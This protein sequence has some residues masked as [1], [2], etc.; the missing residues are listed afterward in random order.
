MA[1]QKLLFTLS[2][3]IALLIAEFSCG[4]VESYENGLKIVNTT[5]FRI[6]P[7]CKMEIHQ[8]NDTQII[9]P[10]T[11]KR[12]TISEPP[13]FHQINKSLIIRECTLNGWKTNFDSNTCNFLYKNLFC[14]DDFHEFSTKY[15]LLCLKISKFK[16]IWNDKLCY[17]SDK[18]IFDL[19]SNE[20]SILFKYFIDKLKTNEFWLPVK[21]YNYSE[22]FNKFFPILWRLPGE[23]WGHLF[24]KHYYDHLSYNECLVLNFNHTNIISVSMTNCTT[25]KMKYN[26]CI[27]DKIITK[28]SWCPEST[29]YIRLDKPNICFGIGSY[30]VDIKH[31][32][33]SYDFFLKNKPIVNYL[34]RK[35]KLRDSKI[36][37][38][39]FIINDKNGENNSQ[40]LLITQDGTIKIE[41]DMNLKQFNYFNLNIIN[42]KQI[43]K[44]SMKLEFYEINKKLILTVYNR[45]YIFRL[46]S[47]ENDEDSSPDSDEIGISCF[48]NSDHDLIKRVE[49][50]DLIW[51]NE[52]KTESLFELKLY[53]KGPGVYWCEAHTIYDFQLIESTKVIATKKIKGNN[54][55]FFM[56]MP[57]NIIECNEILFNMKENSKKIEKTIKSAR[58]FK[59]FIKNLFKPYDIESVKIM[60]IEEILPNGIIKFICHA[61]VSD[62]F[63][64]HDDSSEE[65]SEE[66]LTYHPNMDHRTY[67][68]IRMRDYLIEILNN[69][70]NN[71]QSFQVN[72]T[73]YCLGDISGNQWKTVERGKM[74][75][76][77]EL[78]ILKNGLLKIRNCIGDFIYGATWQNLTQ[79]NDVCIKQKL[80][81]LITK[82]LYEIE[83]FDPAKDLPS[84]VL[85]SV[86]Q[87]LKNIQ[88]Q[89]NITIIAAD[90][91]YL[92]QIFQKLKNEII[93][94]SR[95][96]ESS[97]NETNHQIDLKSS[98][99]KATR[100]QFTQEFI[101]HVV[102]FNEI[103]DYLMD[104]NKTTMI[105]SVKLNSTNTILDSF[106]SII[107]S[108]STIQNNYLNETFENSINNFTDIL[109][110]DQTNKSYSDL[111]V[112]LQIYSNVMIFTIDPIIANITGIVIYSDLNTFNQNITF[113]N[114][115]YD[116]LYKNQSKEELLENERLEVASFFPESLWNRIGEIDYLA[117][118]TRVIE[119][120]RP[121]IVIKI[122]RNDALFIEN[123]EITNFKVNSK[124][125]SISIPG[126]SNK[127][128]D[129]LPIFM[130]DYQYE[131]INNE[132]G[133]NTKH[134]HY[135]NYGNWE[136]DGI[137]FVRKTHHNIANET[138]IME[139]G[140]LHLTPFAFL[141]GGTYNLSVSTDDVTITPIHEEALDIITLL[142]CS[143]S[144]IGV[145]GIFMTALVFKSWREKASTKI[146]L[147]LSIAI[148]LQMILFCFINTEVLAS[149]LIEMRIF[150]SCIILGALMH[151][152]ILVQFSWMFIIAYLQYKRYVQVL[153]N[154]RPNRFLL[155]SFLFG[156][157]VPT[158]P[159]L[160]IILIDRDAYIPVDKSKICYPTGAALYYGTLLPIAIVVSAN[161]IIFFIIFINLLRGNGVNLRH[162]EKKIAMSQLRLLILL[163]FLLGL[164]WIF[165]FLSTMRFGLVFS[166]L[167]CL[168]ATSQGFVL[169]IYFVILDPVTRKLWISYINDIGNF[170]K[171]KQNP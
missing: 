138:I 152:S 75:T 64:F 35:Y 36:F 139:C 114:Y 72:S 165:G 162:T 47:I 112:F 123:R 77:H 38:K 74:A 5:G 56:Q 144:I 8:I 52:M 15:G 166:Y 142:G 103:F 140:T 88:N 134:C 104:F 107:D 28:V 39:R 80:Y 27:F 31:N 12:Y 136:N 13:C 97:Q 122:Y 158:I 102:E 147:Q 135:W 81:S 98:A 109:L 133:K 9:W 92:G 37:L 48:T 3:I 151:F 25:D 167:F 129:T 124:I 65:S 106:E 156:W 94:T 10:E 145:I 100:I 58:N 146:L 119:S 120:I 154:K 99:R 85:S 130:R 95:S 125:I 44:V 22:N 89:K 160:L 21:R 153:G 66:I 83:K 30:N 43:H 45:K 86:H 90:I 79:Q 159:V 168:T 26:L 6:T 40:N 105:L 61:V 29:P 115:E 69:I 50:K 132:T 34:F 20:Q 149:H 42:L 70:P 2:H 32:E 148:M 164:T 46:N 16:E 51:E 53:G 121:K 41:S 157:I 91:Y 113:L 33:N 17:G 169:F 108:I 62:K 82:K 116:F 126:Y 84:K 67:T 18:S 19:K 155:K 71:N 141:V 171:S 54:F 117:N 161:F 163:F 137:R 73:D 87:T 131:D 60:G 23:N 24:K 128:P 93:K 101:K 127:L 111:G 14:P 59:Q 49:I 11:R 170:R 118:N 96:I 57:C 55:A 110:F 63:L 1:F 4:S 7:L 68:R 150:S 76:T 143:L 78:C